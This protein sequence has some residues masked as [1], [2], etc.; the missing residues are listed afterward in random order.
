MIVVEEAVVGKEIEVAVLGNL[1]PQAATPGEIVPGDEFYSYDDKYVSDQS[2]AVIP[3][4]I[5]DAALAEARNL[6]SAP[7]EHC[8]ARGCPASTS[9]GRILPT[10]TGRGRG[11]LCNEVNTMPGFTPI[12]MFPKMWIADGVTYPEIID[13]LVGL[14]ARTPRPSTPQH[15]TLNRRRRVASETELADTVH[16]RRP[17][18]NHD[19][20]QTLPTPAPM[21]RPEPGDDLAQYFAES[22]GAAILPT[23]TTTPCRSG[24]VLPRPA[25][26]PGLSQRQL[27]DHL[28][29]KESTITKWESG[30]RSPRGQRVS[31]LAGILGVSLSW[32][33]VGR[34][35]EPS[36]GDHDVAQLRAELR[37]ARD[38]LDD[39]VSELAVIDK[40]LAA[41][42]D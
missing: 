26:L 11:F 21:I 5:G 38:R 28:G 40:R 8:A 2:F 13:R 6:R 14:R 27:A 17:E 15:Q 7:T 12:S 34:G 25:T 23:W 20:E 33:L 19:L 32:I 35:V 31:K 9:S 18:R 24:G 22:P 36:A 37:L 29:V 41:M 42:D 10:R 16:C 30:E 1:D 3:A 4:P 39:V